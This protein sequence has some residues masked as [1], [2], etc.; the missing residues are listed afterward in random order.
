MSGTTVSEG[1]P[2]MYYFSCTSRTGSSQALQQA[3]NLF[4]SFLVF[5]LLFSWAFPLVQLVHEQME[6]RKPTS[7]E[8]PLIFKAVQNDT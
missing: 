1:P 7:P 4:L 3:I 8:I 6:P 2:T 5:F